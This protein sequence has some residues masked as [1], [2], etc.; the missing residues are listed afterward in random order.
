[1]AKLKEFQ[2]NMYKLLKYT[3]NVIFT[4]KSNMIFDGLRNFTL[5]METLHKKYLNRDNISFSSWISM[6]TAIKTTSS[7]TRFIC[8]PSLEEIESMFIN[9]KNSIIE[10]ILKFHTLIINKKDDFFC[11]DYD[12][13]ST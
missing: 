2:E 11:E 5:D 1:M 4:T 6:K 3:D 7:G 10:S 8:N 12:N 9:H 13:T